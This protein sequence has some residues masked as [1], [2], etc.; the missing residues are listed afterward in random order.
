MFKINNIICYF[1]YLT[2]L[3]KSNR[4]AYSGD[5]Y[6]SNDNTGLPPIQKLMYNEVG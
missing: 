1:S 4:T 5:I 2:Q 3:D 6:N